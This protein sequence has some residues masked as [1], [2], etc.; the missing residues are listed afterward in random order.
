MTVNHEKDGEHTCCVLSIDHSRDER[1]R[2][3]YFLRMEITSGPHA[4]EEL[5]K[6]YRLVSRDVTEHF[7]SDLNLLGIHAENHNELEERKDLVFGKRV[8]VR[9]QTNLQGFR[10]CKILKAVR[11]HFSPADDWV[12]CY[13]AFQEIGAL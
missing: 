6:E 4:G 12:S 9:M 5:V 3:V 7:K 11:G 1:S 13:R 8:L 10:N 2:S